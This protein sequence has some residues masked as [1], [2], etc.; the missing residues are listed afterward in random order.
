MNRSKGRR[1]RSTST[2]TSTQ[3]NYF[4]SICSDVAV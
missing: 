3:N 2:G 1:E 4:L